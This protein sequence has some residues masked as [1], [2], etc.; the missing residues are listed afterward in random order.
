VSNIIALLLGLGL[1]A[2]DYSTRDFTA[3]VA[4]AYLA[5][6]AAAARGLA[7]NPDP[8]VRRLAAEASTRWHR[9]VVRARH[10]WYMAIDPVY[11]WVW[12]PDNP[13]PYKGADR[14]ARY[15]RLAEYAKACGVTGPGDYWG[16]DPDLPRDANGVKRIDGEGFRGVWG[17]NVLRARVRGLPVELAPGHRDTRYPPLK[18]G[19]GPGLP[20]WKLP[21]PA[22]NLPE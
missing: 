10:E 11:V 5:F 12:G 18:P 16:F 8:E 22:P 21:P 19:Y 4:A 17:V 6:D 7:H 9:A 20:T 1:S 13:A 14:E 15:R 2:D 3:R